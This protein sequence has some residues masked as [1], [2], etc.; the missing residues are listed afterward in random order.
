MVSKTSDLHEI[1]TRCTL[2]FV[3][4]HPRLVA[5]SN[6]R[7]LLIV[8]TAT[9]SYSGLLRNR[10]TACQELE[11]LMLELKINPSFENLE[12]AKRELL[13]KLPTVKSSHRCEALGRGLGYGSHSAARAASKM[14][15]DPVT[16]DGQAFQKYLE[17]Q[18]FNVSPNVL[19]RAIAKVAIANVVTANELLSIWGI[20]YGRSQ[21]KPD[22]KWEDPQERYAR[23]KEHRSELLDD[24]AI[25]PFLLSLAL[26]TGVVRT[27]TIRQGTGSYGVKHIAENFKCTY[28][29]GEKLG[30]HYVPNGVLIAAAIHAGF[31]KK[32]HF[33]ELGYHS[34]N[35]TFNMSK[36]CLDDL[37]YEIRPDSGRSQDQRR[38]EERRRLKK[39]SPTLWGL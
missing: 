2:P 4:G 21:R 28:P 31:M 10:R 37:D 35:V 5:E 32:S 25:T 26:L 18:G 7:N 33:D 14:T 24:Y 19:Y 36:P 17:S 13:K 6:V 1:P 30:P 9:A 39:A 29:D 20:G 38:A 15:A 8:P 27:K 23:F 16:V 34:L 3:V 11:M 12:A 22:G